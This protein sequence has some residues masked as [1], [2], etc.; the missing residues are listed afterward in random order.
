MRAPFI[1]MLFFLFANMAIKGQVYNMIDNPSFS[2]GFLSSHPGGLNESYNY[3][4]KLFLPSVGIGYSQNGPSL[5][6]L[7]KKDAAGDFFINFTQEENL[8]DLNPYRASLTVNT[9]GLAVN[10]KSWNFSIG[11][12]ARIIGHLNFPRQTYSLLKDGNAPFI[13]EEISVGVALQASSFNQYMLGASY[14]TDIFRIG[15]CGK[16]LVGSQDVSTEEFGVRLF[17]D[18][19]I[20]QL[21]FNNNYIINTSSL[22]T[23]NDLEDFSFDLDRTF[24]N[25]L[26][27]NNVGFGFDIGMSFKVSENT[28]VGASIYDVGKI[29]WKEE[30]TNY[31]SKGGFSFDGLDIASYIGSETVVELRD[32]LLNLLK[33]EET[34]NSYDSKLPLQFNVS[35]VHTLNDKLDVEAAFNLATINGSSAYNF[36]V[37]AL[38]QFNSYSHLG[39]SYS[40]NQ[41]E[42]LNLGLSIVSKLGPVQVF[43]RTDNILGVFQPIKNGYTNGYLGINLLFGTP[44]PLES[45]L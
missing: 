11:H 15:I 20:Y 45:P 7:I 6:D 31:N 44:E 24:I 23:F 12:A 18:D 13:G 8:E 30:A 22:F 38:Y 42:I 28:T 17:T 43:A 39:A 26:F 41:F 34:N 27:S 19:D 9:I 3:R 10:W 37:G 32:S 35:V 36:R 2:T 5:Y 1:C 14:G 16:L 40:Y 25:T 29:I 21:R 4:I 33:F